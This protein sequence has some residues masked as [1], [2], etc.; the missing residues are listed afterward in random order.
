[1][2]SGV[3]TDRRTQKCLRATHNRLVDAASELLVERRP[4]GAVVGRNLAHRLAQCRVI[5]V[6]TLRRVRERGTTATVM[7]APAGATQRSW[8]PF[9]ANKERISCFAQYL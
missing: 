1:M 6:D 7:S 3:I 2:H 5:V 8:A 4:A 9:V